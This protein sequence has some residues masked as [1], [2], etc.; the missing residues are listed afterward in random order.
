M[1]AADGSSTGKLLK[2]YKTEI[3]KPLAAILTLNTIAHTVGAIMVGVQATQIWG[4]SIVSTMV[5]PAVMTLAILIL[6]EI[7]PK[8]LG[9]NYWS[10]L[11]NFTVKALRIIIL[12]LWPLVWLSQVITKFLKKNKEESVLSRREFR[13]M[14]AVAT[15]QGVFDEQE[16]SIMH[17]LL[18]F[19]TVQVKD[20]M[21]PRTVLVAAD[22][23]MTIRE[24]Y[25]GRDKIRFS[26]IPIFQNEKDNI[27]G[28]VLRSDILNA[29]IRDRGSE[30]LKNLRRD[31]MVARPDSSIM[32]IFDQLMERREHIALV[33]DKY[34][35]TAGLVS[36]EDV[37]ETLLGMEIVDE[38]DGTTDMQTLARRNWEKRAVQLGLTGGV[39]PEAEN[40][41]DIEEKK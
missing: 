31:M 15:E 23:E 9:A 5:V 14:T 41:P 39:A 22:E 8:T 24:F 2:Q 4:E 38:T 17:N 12:V 29:I 40:A 10:G 33:V 30:P 7:I 19:K 13:M 11:A 27:T 21:T 6:S 16:S 37:I 35:G 25:D 26:R 32:D 3:D 18:K 1:R 28:M 36:M 20:I 34:G